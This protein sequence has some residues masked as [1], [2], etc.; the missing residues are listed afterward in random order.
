MAFFTKIQTNFEAITPILFLNGKNYTPLNTRNL[1][2]MQKYNRKGT[3]IHLKHY[4]INLFWLS[5]Y[6]IILNKTIHY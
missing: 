2:I 5:F 4:L 1:I 3:D 6:F